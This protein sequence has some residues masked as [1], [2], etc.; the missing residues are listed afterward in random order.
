MEFLVFVTGILVL[1]FLL[2]RAESN[3]RQ[4]ELAVLA[5]E[6]S[7]NFQ[8]DATREIF[9]RFY[10]LCLPSFGYHEYAVNV[11]EGEA[12][13]RGIVSFDIKYHE[14]LFAQDRAKFVTVFVVEVPLDSPPVE[15]RPRIFLSE[16]LFESHSNQ[17]RLDSIEFEDHY[18]VFSSD[19]R[20]AYDICNSMLMNYLLERPGLHVFFARDAIACLYEFAVSPLEYEFCLDQ[21]L[22]LA[23]LIPRHLELEEGEDTPIPHDT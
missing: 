22:E 4:R 16:S 20:F 1:Y 21:M 2:M 5:R 7:L 15:I 23:D 14:K 19:P 12:E 8:S 11:M 9:E 10:F 13:G 18:R 6:L 17:V 3:S